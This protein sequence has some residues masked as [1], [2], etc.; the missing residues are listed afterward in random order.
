MS[1]AAKSKKILNKYALL[2]VFVVI[3]TVF[4]LISPP[5]LSVSNISNM[6]LG[7]MASAYL[8]FGGI[9]I[10]VIN[11][12]D[13][14]LGYNLCLSM[15][16]A[17]FLD[18]LGAPGIIT[19][20]LPLALGTCYGILNGLMVVKLKISSMIVTLAVGL[21][22]SGISQA[23]T[24]GGNLYLSS[25]AWLLYFAR[26]SVF[27]IAIC[28]IVWFLIGIVL[29]FFLTQTP[30][31]RQMF[32]VGN[33]EKTAFLAGIKT[34]G[35]RMLAFACAGFFASMGGLIMVGQ[36]G[37][38]SSAYGV[39]LLLPAYAVV[40]LSRASFKPG[41]INVPGVIVS[42]LLILFGT[43][44]MQ[45]IGAPTWSEYLFEGI[46]LM[47][48]MWLSTRTSAAADQTAAGRKRKG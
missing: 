9:F 45:L 40:F 7:G 28:A 18:T 5:F 44:G 22:L 17:A 21:T 25:P 27:R 4:G 23:I 2:I 8:A 1:T 37:S 32:A 38:A 26:K 43:N 33:S 39:S 15:C 16:T 41:Y 42:V 46:I 6:L 13:L 14:S 20:L 36:L 30:V 29:H 12:F 35:I 10:L 3:I 24:N 48:S 31:G 47:F 11:E 34:D 19:V